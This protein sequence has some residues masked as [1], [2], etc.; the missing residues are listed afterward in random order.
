MIVGIDASNIRGGGGV[1]HLTEL[2]GVGE[3]LRHGFS[4]VIVWAGQATLRSVQDRPWLI[5]RTHPLLDRSLA[6]RIFWQRFRLS[7]VARMAGCDL[8]FVP[9]GS[10][11]GTFHPVVT[12]S[13]NLLPFIWKEMVRYGLTSMALKW[14]LLRWAQTST[15]R[16]A[17]GVIFLTRHAQQAVT[18]V[19]GLLPG[20]VTIVPH[21]INVR[22]LRAPRLQ[23]ALSDCSTTN[24]FRLVY[25]SIIDAYKHQWNVAEAVCRLHA[26]GLPVVLDL[27]GPAYAPA[28]KRL[29]RVL[30]RVDPAHTVVRYLGSVPHQE[31]HLMYGRADA[32]VFAS[33]C[34]NMPNILLEGMASGLPIACSD[35]G[36]MP[37]VLG[38]AGIYFDPE[39]VSS[40]C[41]ALQELLASP[42]LRTDKARAAFD[43]VASYSWG[44]CAEST[45]RFL[46]EVATAPPSQ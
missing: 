42:A 2:L 22:F 4:K 7:K 37:E 39:D 45:F 41:G 29:Q 43:R 5:K 9:G 1:T 35:R 23:R 30:Q 18:K 11:A 17:D 46:A 10:Y 16:S 26:N 34:E 15:F 27:V 31:L 14:W 25:V 36:P 24:P 44:Q 12:M 13:R 32:C 8:L 3:P 20:K 19:T 33:T 28:L 40:I 38:D 21:G 6:C